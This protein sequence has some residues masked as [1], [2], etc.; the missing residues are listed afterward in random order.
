MANLA[1]VLLM[2]D[3][4]I[5]LIRRV[6]MLRRTWLNLSTILALLAIPSLAVAQVK[7]ELKFPDDEKTMS[8]VK[9]G[10]KQSL[11]IVGMAIDTGS[12]QEM[13]I[14]TTNGKRGPDG[15][16]KQQQ[17]IENMKA[18]LTLPGGVALQF[19]STQPD[20]PPSGTQFDALIDLI[21]VN[22]KASWT[23]IRG[24]DNRVTAIEGRDKV[25]E[26]LD[27]AK[28][29]MLKKQLDPAYLRD[30][31]NKELDKLPSKP[32][33]KGD[34][35]EVTENVRLE[36]GQNMSF[37]S[38]YTYEGPVER[39]GRQLDKIAGNISEV[40]YS[41]DPDA[42]LPLKFN[43][44]ELKPEKSDVA[45]YFDREKGAIVESTS[46][47]QI[48]GT[49]NFEVNGNALPAQLDLTM[50]SSTVTK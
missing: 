43:G 22:A 11:T 4:H 24:K 19:D 35:W 32:V 45:I 14:S 15:V 3:D 48:K 36:Q 12:E 27:E 28:Q 21:K 39:N 9:I 7:L 38:K 13:S 6:T 44:A 47:V 18:K 49:L 10:T 40:T 31:A 1:S 50:S 41:V 23:V 34:S 29:A 5:L 8:A 42:G 16:L 37:K 26:G 30:T 33:N 20:A 46:T 25:L 17:K 2:F